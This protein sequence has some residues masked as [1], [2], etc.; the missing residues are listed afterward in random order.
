[1]GRLPPGT[2][3]SSGVARRE[4]GRDPLAEMDMDGDE[5]KPRPASPPSGNRM[6]LDGI[7]I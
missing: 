5:I 7:G 3:S 1:M 2:W 6:Q 4:H